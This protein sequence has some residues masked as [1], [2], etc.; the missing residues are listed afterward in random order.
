MRR[1][2]GGAPPSLMS[3]A[4]LL[5]AWQC[6]WSKCVF[7][8]R[9]RRHNGGAFSR[10]SENFLS[11]GS[12][13]RPSVRFRPYLEIFLSPDC[14]NAS[15]CVFSFCWN[16]SKFFWRLGDLCFLAQVPCRLRRDCSLL[17]LA[18]SLTLQDVGWVNFTS[19][20][21]RRSTASPR[22]HAGYIPVY[23]KSGNFLVK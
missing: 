3:I 14:E 10:S 9:V 21:T 1:H 11:P 18:T 6:I 23:F 13:N 22:L 4:Y 16:F 2:N 12:R 15:R 5:H 8:T 17:C 7:R 20:P 19:P